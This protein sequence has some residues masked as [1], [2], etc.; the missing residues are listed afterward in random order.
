MQLVSKI[1]NLYVITSQQ[2]YRRTDGQTDDMRSQSHTLTLTTAIRF[3]QR[4]PNN[5]KKNNNK[6]K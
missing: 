6:I 2:R 3:Q 4:R 1:A 5:K